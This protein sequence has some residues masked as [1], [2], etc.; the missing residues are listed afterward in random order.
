VLT[1]PWRAAK[2]LVPR[3]GRTGRI[4]TRRDRT[5]LAVVWMSLLVLLVIVFLTIDSWAMRIGATVLA[6][7]LGP[8]LVALT[9]P[10]YHRSVRR[11]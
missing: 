5:Q 1:A 6:L 4:R 8:V 11:S 2:A 10:A 7:L 3:R 9:R